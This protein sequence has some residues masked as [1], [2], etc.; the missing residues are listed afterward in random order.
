VRKA[1]NSSWAT[2]V[3]DD[4]RLVLKLAGDREYG[5]NH[6]SG[7]A[8]ISRVGD[9]SPSARPAIP[10]YSSCALVAPIHASG[11]RL[12]AAPLNRMTRNAN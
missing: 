8:L 4:S 7:R 3:G 6:R 11:K 1:G 10:C 5:R 2:E 9:I 12:E